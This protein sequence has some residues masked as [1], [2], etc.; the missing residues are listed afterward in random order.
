M[1]AYCM[2]ESNLLATRMIGMDAPWSFRAM[3]ASVS[4]ILILVSTTMT[5]TSAVFMAVLACRAIAP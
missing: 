4:V 3:T 2:S 5:I 1:S